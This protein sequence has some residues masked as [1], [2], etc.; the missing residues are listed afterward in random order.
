MVSVSILSEMCSI[1]YLHIP[2]LL[3]HQPFP[4]FNFGLAECDYL[5]A[6][7]LTQLPCCS[8]LNDSHRTRE[9]VR[10]LCRTRNRGKLKQNKRLPLHPKN[11]S[12]SPE[13][14]NP[15]TTTKAPGAP[16][17]EGYNAAACYKPPQTPEHPRASPEPRDLLYL[18]TTVVFV[19]NPTES[20]PRSLAETTKSS[21]P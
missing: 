17:H 15:A 8:R 21:I 5:K 16:E 14:R 2:P 4:S 20:P 18:A 12:K 10:I 6:I 9:K 7:Y 11:K 3:Q 19:K 1:S 13:P